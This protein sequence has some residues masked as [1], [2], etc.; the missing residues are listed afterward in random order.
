MRTTELTS[1]RAGHVSLAAN[2]ARGILSLGFTKGG[3]RR[4]VNE[5]VSIDDGFLA[6]KLAR[7]LRGKAPDDPLWPATPL[8]IRRGFAL[9]VELAGLCR[10]EFAPYSLRRG[11]AT[12]QFQQTGSLDSCIVRGRWESVRTA[13]GY[14]QDGLAIQGG[15]RL[16]PLE[17][18]ALRTAA[19]L[20]WRTL[21]PEN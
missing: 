21:G 8:Q 4:N 7:L 17:Q 5:V 19:V 14:I 2:H 13:R 6:R 9:L 16:R 15:L 1:V 18:E 10:F 12:W 20:W 11:G 3:K